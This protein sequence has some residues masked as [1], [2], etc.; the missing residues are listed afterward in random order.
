MN[1]ELYLLYIHINKINQKCYIGITKRD[2]KI[3]WGTNGNGYKQQPKFYNAIEKYGWDNFLHIILL[4]NLSEEE[5][6]ELESEYI[7]KYNSINNGYNILPKGIQSYPRNKPV[8]CK[9]TNTLYNS[10]KEAAT[11]INTTSTYIIDNCKGKTSTIK[12]YD[13]YY[14]DINNNK[15][16]DKPI[17][18][19]KVPKNAEP[20]L[21]IETNQIF[22][23]VNECGRTLELDPSG[24]NK[25]L[26]GTR[27]G[28]NGLHFI[29]VKDL[30]NTNL[31]EILCK[32]TGKNRKIYCKE[33]KQIFDNLQEA[34]IFC[35]RTPQSVMKNCQGKLKSCGGYHF[36]YYEDFLRAQGD[37]EESE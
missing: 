16:I 17:F 3:R 11:A 29:R 1:D 12:G 2:P 14:W 34:S 31:I 25:A 22:P 10:I 37:E 33:T 15:I 13:F 26:N 5:A 7:E 20:V 36:Q 32:K 18:I 35:Q 23:S 4:D 30:P 8:Y 28:I 6:I 24:L 9:T 19:K 27:N 21:C